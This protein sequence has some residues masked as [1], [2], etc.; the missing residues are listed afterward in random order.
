M[1]LAAQTKPKRLTDRE[2]ISSNDNDQDNNFLCSWDTLK[3]EKSSLALFKL[4]VKAD[5][6][7]QMFGSAVEVD[8]Q[9]KWD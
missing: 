9:I 1:F 5:N 4:M 6:K 7:C 8:Y 2:G 3:F